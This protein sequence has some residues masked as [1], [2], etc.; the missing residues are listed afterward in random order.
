MIRT[1][2]ELFNVAPQMQE[3]L[4]RIWKICHVPSKQ[5]PKGA[6]AYTHFMADF[7]EIRMLCKPFL[8]PSPPENKGA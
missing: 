1:S 6:H 4:E 8:T 7:D 5:H 3:A 2:T